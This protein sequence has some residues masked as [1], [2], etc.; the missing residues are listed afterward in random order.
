MQRFVDGQNPT[1]IGILVSHFVGQT[2]KLWCR[3]VVTL[4]SVLFLRCLSFRLIQEREK[5]KGRE[6]GVQVESLKGM[7]SSS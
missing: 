4:S 5:W 7:D 3:Q 2:C 6:H 1:L